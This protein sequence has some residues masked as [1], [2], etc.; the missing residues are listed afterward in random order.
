MF[1]PLAEWLGVAIVGLVG[2]SASGESRTL[3]GT[4]VIV[5][6]VAGVLS[7]H[8]GDLFRLGVLVVQGRNSSG[9][10]TT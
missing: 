7:G 6:I 10:C 3:T 4:S 5:W 2:W 8:P 1:A 9:G